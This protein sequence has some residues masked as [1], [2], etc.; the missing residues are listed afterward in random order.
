MEAVALVTAICSLLTTRPEKVEATAPCRR[1]G[2]LGTAFLYP[3]APRAPQGVTLERRLPNTWSANRGNRNQ[4]LYGVPRMFYWLLDNFGGFKTA[5]ERALEKQPVDHLYIDMNAIIHVATHGNV[6]PLVQ[7]ENEQRLRRITSA[8][9]MLF[10]VVQPRKML[11]MA[12]DGVCPT[13]KINQQRGRRF[14]TSKSIDQLVSVASLDPHGVQTEICSAVS[15]KDGEKYVAQRL[16]FDAYDNVTFNPNYISPGTDFMQIVDSEVANWL[17]LK[18]VEGLFGKCLVV[19]SG[20]SVPGEGEHKIFQCIRKMNK[21]SRHARKETHLVY[22]LDADLMMLSMALKIPNIKVL[23]EEGKYAP[24]VVAKKK[25]EP[26]FATDTGIVHLHKWDFID[27]KQANFEVVSIRT[28]RKRMYER[29]LRHLIK[30]FRAS[31]FA[32]LNRPEAPYRITDDFVLLSFLAGNDFLPRLPTVDFANDS[33]SEMIETYYSLLQRWKGFLTDG[34]KIH[35]PRLQSLFKALTK[36]EQRWFKEKALIEEVEQYSN[37]K[38]YADY[39]HREKCQVDGKA[40]I[41]R[42]CVD[43]LKGLFWILSYYHHDCP[44]WDWSYR[45]HYSPLVSDLADVTKVDVTFNKGG[46]IT[47]LE[48]LLAI[49]PPN[50]N[51]LLPPSYRKLA[52]EDGELRQYFPT[53]FDI[54]EDGRTNEWEHVVKLPFVNTHKL[55]K[56]AQKVNPG[57]KYSSLYKNKKGHIYVYQQPRE[58]DPPTADEA[59]SGKART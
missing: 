50:G 48:H 22:G 9:E 59:D 44:S 21:A 51:E 15:S 39:Y 41:R 52:K 3:G 28:L 14:R 45:Y 4:P 10:N 38:L 37:P 23:R 25:G 57:L 5:L 26:F 12:V 47:P 58:P 33:F 1:A 2:H 19:Y 40:E 31:N 7:M 24:H 49:S 11:Y 6:S 55:V 56:A 46:P 35:V 16:P 32:F 54:N 34:L 36:N 30:K 20:V 27:L 17:A 42:M 13:A 29:C 53:E 43:Y 8:I 18:T